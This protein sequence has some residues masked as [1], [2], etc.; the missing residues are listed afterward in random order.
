MS[1]RRCKACGTIKPL[2]EF[3]TYRAKGLHGHRHKCRDCWNAQWTPVVVKHHNRYYH[4][5]TNGYRER[6][7]SRTAQ[8]HKEQPAQHRHRNREYAKRHP[9]KNAAKVAV[10]MAVRSGKLLRQP[11][12]VCGAK[13]SHAH[14][15]DYSKPLEV[16]WLCPQH[17]GERHRIINR[18]TAVEAS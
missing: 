9:E 12:E 1:E 7:K 17:H 16:I 15:N 14:H 10:M 18:R 11:C 3:P 8:Q 5:N 13:R 2:N 4:E 6:Q